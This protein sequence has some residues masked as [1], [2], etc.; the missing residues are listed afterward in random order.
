MQCLNKFYGGFFTKIS[1]ANQ[2]GKFLFSFLPYHV[3]SQV[4]RGFSINKEIVIK[5]LRSSSL[6]AQRIV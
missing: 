2:C 5:N 4:E 1:I 3:Q 6:S